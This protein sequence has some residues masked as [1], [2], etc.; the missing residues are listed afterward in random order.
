[1]RTKSRI[2]GFRRRASTMLTHNVGKDSILTVAHEKVKRILLIRA[3]QRLGNLLMITPIV[4]E[5]GTIFPNATIDLLVKKG[6][7][8]QI[9]ETNPR[10]GKI[11][12]LPRKPFKALRTY[13]RTW[14]SMRDET[15]DLVVNVVG[16][17]SSGRLATQFA[18]S[19]AKFF[20]DDW[21]KG[22]HALKHHMAVYPVLNLRSFLDMRRAFPIPDMS[23]R[24]SDEERQRGLELLQQTAGTTKNVLGIFTYA[25][26]V[27]CYSKEWWDTMYTQL[28]RAFPDH[29]IIEILPAENVSQIDFKAPAYYSLDIRELG[30]F[31]SNLSLFVGADSGMMHLA[32]ASGVTTVGLFSATKTDIYRPYGHGSFA[33]NTNEGDAASWTERIREAV[34]HNVMATS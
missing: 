9:F 34:T 14:W 1:M 25:T 7:A 26:G 19:R 4:E 16:H 12:E 6:P 20:G 15:Y 24:I 31:L 32:A 28:Q 29:Q 10:I 8:K 27:K 30:G 13:L 22:E 17:S 2:D 3:N 18:R 21:F 11:L 5:L 33:I 23:L